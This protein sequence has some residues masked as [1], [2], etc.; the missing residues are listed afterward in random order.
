MFFDYQIWQRSCDMIYNFKS[1]K[2]YIQT[3]PFFNLSNKNKILFKSEEFYYNKIRDGYFLLDRSNLISCRNYYSDSNGSLRDVK[4]IT[5][6]AYAL[7]NC[8]GVY[9]SDLFKYNDKDKAVFYAGNY[10]NQDLGYSEEY[11]SFE[12][13]I[14]WNQNSYKY[15]IKLDIK[16]FYDSISVDKLFSKIIEIENFSLGDKTINFY[17]ELL[18]SVGGGK[19]PTIEVMPALSFLASIIYLEESENLIIDYLKNNYKVESFKIIRYVDD[20]FILLNIKDADIDEI[21]MDLI[22]KYSSILIDVGLSLNTNKLSKGLTI[23]INDYLKEWLYDVETKTKKYNLQDDFNINLNEFLKSLSNCDIVTTDKYCSLVEESFY[24]ENITLDPYEILNS[25]SRERTKH[26]YNLTVELL[27]KIIGNNIEIIRLDPKLFTRIILNTNNGKL[28]TLFIDKIKGLSNEDRITDYELCSVIQY[29]SM[30]SF[31]HREFKNVIKLYDNNLYNYIKEYCDKQS[32]ISYTNHLQKL[33]FTKKDVILNYLYCMYVFE[34]IRNN[35]FSK[36]AYYK[37]FFDRCTAILACED[38][39]RDKKGKPDYG[40]YYE[41]KRLCKYY[42]AAK[43]KDIIHKA[44]MLRH[45]NPLVH[46]NATQINR[47][48][49]VEI[50]EIIPKLNKLIE[51]KLINILEDNY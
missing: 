21:F 14:N 16:S 17:K 49:I 4:L 51:Y 7:L 25:L 37:T 32:W 40:F 6:I 11:Q 9:L 33:K 36:Y 18:L 31:V 39:T 13:I 26:E 28:I 50:D 24:L 43:S 2:N 15:F 19:F 10:E 27:L 20:T 12:R 5:P 35:H 45:T 30:R 34:D 23:N 29:L 44:N 46:S 48:Y 1:C 3:Y 22:T 47:N 8:F 38:G 41:E 42:G